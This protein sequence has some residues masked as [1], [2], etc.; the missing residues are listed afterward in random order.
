MA[1]EP[2]G[3]A[4]VVSLAQGVVLGPW[5]SVSVTFVVKVN[6]RRPLSDDGE[7]TRVSSHDDVVVHVVHDSV[8]LGILHGS[9]VVDVLHDVS[10]SWG[11]V[12]VNPAVVIGPEWAGMYVVDGTVNV[13]VAVII[14]MGTS[15]TPG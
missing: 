2:D 14:D 12:R 7:E 9:V 1:S 3:T 13:K 11:T 10:D 6:V 8:V 15:C 4:M 5:F